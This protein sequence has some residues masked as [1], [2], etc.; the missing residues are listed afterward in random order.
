MGCLDCDGSAANG[1]GSGGGKGGID[2]DKLGTDEARIRAGLAAGGFTT[3]GDL[4]GSLFRSRGFQDTSLQAH[5]EAPDP[6]F[7]TNP[8]PGVSFAIR[9]NAGVV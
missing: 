3:L 1:S 8:R 6:L 2:L 7:I 4:Y 5:N 9:K